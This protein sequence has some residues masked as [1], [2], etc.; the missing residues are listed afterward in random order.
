MRI[1][2]YLALLLVCASCTQQPNIDVAAQIDPLAEQYVRL[3]N[4][5]GTRSHPQAAKVDLSEFSILDELI[6]CEKEKLTH[7][8]MYF[9]GH[10]QE[11]QSPI[12]EFDKPVGS[13]G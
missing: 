11:L 3:A 13:V 1:A 5:V 7:C 10:R 9:R 12:R 8:L 2:K 6:Q 4:L